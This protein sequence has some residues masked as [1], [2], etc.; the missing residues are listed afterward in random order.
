MS[1]FTAT[2]RAVLR[3]TPLML[4]ISLGL[5]TAAALALIDNPLTA[6]TRAL[7]AWDAAV[8]TYLAAVWAQTRGVT[9]KDMARHAADIDDGR[10]FVLFVSLFAVAASVT[11]I[12]LELQARLAPGLAKN[13]HVGFVFLTVALSWLFVHT[14][15]AKHYAHEYFGPEDGGGVRE[16][17]LFPGG[18]PPDFAD[19][20][21]VA[22]VIGVANQTADV[23]IASKAIR[24]IVTL[25]GVVAFV[26][27]TVI[28]ALTINLAAG[29]FN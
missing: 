9:A 26:F 23:Q 6:L 24:R 21:H 1:E 16:G 13:L 17:L 22:L 28:L 2:L 12:V 4:A 20:F 14:S 7:V 19:F 11:A 8:A 3:H 25:H 18:E 5:V 27:N 15:F 29:L 10:D